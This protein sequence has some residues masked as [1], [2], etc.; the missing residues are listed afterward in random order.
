MGSKRL[1]LARLEA[2]MKGFKSYPLLTGSNAYQAAG[3]GLCT[4]DQ[5]PLVTPTGSLS[6]SFLDD[7]T[8]ATAKHM[9]G[10]LVTNVHQYSSGMRLYVNN[11]GVKT[12]SFTD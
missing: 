8:G 12:M 1:G 11:V 3:R 4:F 10:D 6:S 5:M 2:L 7:G 9:L